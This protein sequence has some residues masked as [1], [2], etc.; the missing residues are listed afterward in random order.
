ML[1]ESAPKY[2]LG[3]PATR[4]AVG[5]WNF[6][7]SPGCSG[8]SVRARKLPRAGGLGFGDTQRRPIS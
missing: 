7:P 6:V 8:N 5:R 3:A 2:L 1:N 4:A